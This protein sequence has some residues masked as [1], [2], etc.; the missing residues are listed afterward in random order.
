MTCKGARGHWPLELHALAHGWSRGTLFAC[1]V[2][3]LLY[4]FIKR[5]TVMYTCEMRVRTE[6]PQ[7][8]ARRGVPV[9][10]ETR[11][12]SPFKASTGYETN[13][14]MPRQCALLCVHRCRAP[15]RTQ[16][17]GCL[18]MSMFMIRYTVG[19]STSSSVQLYLRLSPHT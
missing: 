13:A 4:L 10:Q 9:L 2:C 12:T 1:I 15:N 14:L 5:N 17:L 16:S 8:C 19:A 7:R 3:Y 6:L 18:L 11:E